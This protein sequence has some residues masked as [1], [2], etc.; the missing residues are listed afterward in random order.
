MFAGILK[1]IG[2]TPLVELKKAM[3]VRF[4]LFA[5]LEGVNPSGSTKDRPALEIVRQ[6]L[7]TGKIRQDTVIVE[8]SS[9]NMGVALAQVCAYL[10]LSFICITDTKATPQHINLLRTYGAKVEIMS[11]P[12]PATGDYLVAR[13]NRAREIVASLGNAFWVNQYANLLN[14][15]AHYRTMEEII[16]ALNGEVDYFICCASSCGTLRGCAEYVRSQGLSRTKIC[17]VDAPGSVI[18]G[19]SR[20]KRSIPGHGAGIRPDLYQDGLVNRVVTVTDMECVIGCRKLLATEAML[21]GGSSGAAF[22]GA[23][24]LRDEIP[25]GANCVV[26]FPDR[27]ER[28]LNT[29]FCDTWVREQFNRSIDECRQDVA[30]LAGPPA[31]A[32]D[33][34][35]A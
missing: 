9:G 24:H 6:G 17:A 35:S 33:N 29:I 30:L 28:Y 7:L 11:E 19:G 27:G 4:H 15:G 2:N 31:A 34:L 1:T 5:K 10:N 20:G 26:L 23:H 18:F 21:V 16:T 14:A 25:D 22:M 13:I 3:D 8:A 12:D 32:A